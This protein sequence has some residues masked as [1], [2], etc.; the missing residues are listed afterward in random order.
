[1]TREH[2]LAQQLCATAD[3]LT[4]W[5]KYAWMPNAYDALMAEAQ[6]IRT[7]LSVMNLLDHVGNVSSDPIQKCDDPDEEIR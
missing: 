6:K 7:M 4:A 2:Q 1:M 3:Q 5:A